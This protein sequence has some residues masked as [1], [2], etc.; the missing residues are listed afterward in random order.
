MLTWC[1]PC[2]RQVSSCCAQTSACMRVRASSAP[3]REAA[4]HIRDAAQAMEATRTA[5]RPS[6]KIPTATQPPVPPI[7]PPLRFS[8][9]EE[10]VYRGAYPSLLNLR[11]LSR[12]NLRSMVSLLP[13]PPAPHLM[14]WC[15]DNGVRNHFERVAPFKEEVVLT[16]ERAAELLQL[17]VLPER[18]PVYVH[19]LDGVAVTGTLIMCLRKLLTWAPPP[20]VAEYARFN[21]DGTEMPTPPAHHI[22]SFV[23]AFKPELELARLLPAQ[24]PIWLAAALGLQTDEEPQHFQSMAHQ[25]VP[26]PAAPMRVAALPDVSDDSHHLGGM[27]DH[28]QHPRPR[29]ADPPPSMQPAPRDGGRSLDALAIE[30]LTMGTAR[31]R[32]PPLRAGDAELRAVASGADGRDGGASSRARPP[33]APPTKQRSFQ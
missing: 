1:C 7:V 27:L 22:V 33:A 18:Q 23:H 25:V 10:G 4:L 21:R 9:V 8:L 32:A 15:E 20:M 12:L 19:C 28:H 3:R 6:T 30:G 5:V 16:H 14:R 26:A 17:L 2:A 13:E 29:E 31:P 24:L 11:F